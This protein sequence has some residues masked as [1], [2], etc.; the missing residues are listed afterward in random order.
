MDTCSRS[1]NTG[2]SHRHL[3]GHVA[4]LPPRLVL[5]VCT[6]L[7][8]LRGRLPGVVSVSKLALRELVEALL[9]TAKDIELMLPLIG[10]SLGRVEWGHG[11]GSVGSVATQQPA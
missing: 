5:I 3:E 9:F 8:A 10:I 2:P 6:A 1:A 7:A 11:R 4:Y